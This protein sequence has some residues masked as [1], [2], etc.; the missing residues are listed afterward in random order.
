MR[1]RAEEDQDLPGRRTSGGLAV[2]AAGDKKL[3]KWTRSYYSLPQSQYDTIM[4][5]LSQAA[6]ANHA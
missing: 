6:E 3:D 5:L 4:W 1:R 2:S